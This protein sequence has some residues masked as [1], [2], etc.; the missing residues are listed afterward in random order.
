[1][2]SPPNGGQYNWSNDGEYPGAFF[3]SIATAVSS[4]DC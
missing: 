4:G 3:D 2:D 1:M